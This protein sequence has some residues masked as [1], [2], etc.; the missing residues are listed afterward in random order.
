M[1]GLREQACSLL[2]AEMERS[3]RQGLEGLAAAAAELYARAARQRN[4]LSFRQSALA[5]LLG[6][7]ASDAGSLPDLLAEISRRRQA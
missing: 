2:A 4:S 5:A 1:C 3:G 6:Y 7:F